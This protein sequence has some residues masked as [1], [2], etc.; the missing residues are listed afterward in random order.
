[1]LI[2]VL[3]DKQ[4]QGKPRKIPYIL[5]R[6]GANLGSANS[7]F[8]P[9]PTQGRSQLRRAEKYTEDQIME[10]A[11]DAGADDVVSEEGAIV[12]YTDQS[13]FESVLNAMTRKISRPS[14]PRSQWFPKPMSPSMAKP[15]ARYSVSSTGSKRT[16][17]SRRH[18]NMELP[19]S[20]E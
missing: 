7:V 12:V 15:R 8:L 17:M 10:A 18:H 5:N 1:M 11:I 14:A 2:E 16:R 3:T 19:E 4:K 13:S 6:S 9:F 20:E